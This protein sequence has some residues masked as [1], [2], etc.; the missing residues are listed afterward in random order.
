MKTDSDI[1]IYFILDK[2]AEKVLKTIDSFGNR[3][4]RNYPLYRTIS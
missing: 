1:Y 4:W 3:A 2:A